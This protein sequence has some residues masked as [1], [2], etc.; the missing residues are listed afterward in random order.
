MP[1]LAS[2]RLVKLAIVLAVAVAWRASRERDLALHKP[3]RIS[4]VRLGDPAGAVNGIVEWGSYAVHTKRD[5]P[6]WFVVDL[7]ERHRI[8]E[9]RVY[10][11]G[12]GYLNDGPPMAVELSEDG[13]RFGR[14]VSCEAAVTQLSPCRVAMGGA[15]ARYVRVLHPTHLVLSEVEVFEAR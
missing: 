15:A 14:P 3:V 13:L 9:V 1:S 10:G 2:P 5:S 12:D 7:E 8:G 4:S 6:A 11:R